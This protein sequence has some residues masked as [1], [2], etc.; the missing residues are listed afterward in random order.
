[1]SKRA[2]SIKANRRE[3]SLVFCI[4]M[5]L[6]GFATYSFP[7]IGE[8]L[9][10]VWAPISG[11]IFFATFGSWKGMLGGVFAFLEELLPGTD[12][13]PSFTIMWFLQHARNKK[14]VTEIQVNPR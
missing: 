6:V 2:I 5:D 11:M 14:Q 10:L 9:D 7:L 8:V 13:I 4:L 1:M 3:P 12:F